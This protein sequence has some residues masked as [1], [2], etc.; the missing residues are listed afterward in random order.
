MNI[1]IVNQRT[2]ELVSRLV[3]VWESSVRATHLFLTEG[4]IQEIK[5]YVPL[6]LK[7]VTNLVIAM[8]GKNTP[9]GFIG[10]ENGCI[11]MLFIDND[12]R[13][14]GAG[15]AL[16]EF[17]IDKYR[18]K[19]VTVN[20]QNVQAV[21]FYQHMGFSVYKRSQYDQQGRPFPLL[22]MSL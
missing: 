21:G 2:E 10:V 15:R 5:T 17:A 19:E 14:T 18:A 11:E 8:D 7:D 4:D 6:A 16:V 20:E 13:G 1:E 22:Y 3:G 9:I 12:R